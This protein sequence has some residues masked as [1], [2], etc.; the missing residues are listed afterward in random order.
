M[1]S[2]TINFSCIGG[3]HHFLHLA[4]VMA[5][6]AT[7]RQCRI[8]VFVVS[9]GDQ[10]AL[11][12]ILARLGHDAGNS[13]LKII[14]MKHPRWFIWLTRLYPKLRKSKLLRMLLWRRAF[15]G[16]D[17]I[18]AAER[19]S[20][21]LQRIPGKRPIMIHIP[22]GAGDRKRGFEPRIRL[23]DHVIA[24]GQ[25][26]RRRMISMGLVKPETCFVSGY[27]KLSGVLKMR[28][29][30][31]EKHIPAFSGN[32]PVVLY[33][34][35]FNAKLSS[36]HAYGYQIID[37]IL[38]DGR[39]DLIVAPHVRLMAGQSLAERERFHALTNNS[40]VLFDAGSE[41]SMDM[42]YTQAADIYLGD[43]S[44]Q[45]Y[46]FMFCPRPC[47][48]F[49]AHGAEWLGNPDYL[50]WTAGAVVSL[51]PALM[52]ALAAA[53]SRHCEFAAVQKALVSNAFGDI[54]GN[55]GQDAAAIILRLCRTNAMPG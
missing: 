25:K 6:L 24:G 41:K 47:V 37:A 52:A 30:R 48:F 10:A 38:A 14:I 27:V 15:R 39:Y 16:G 20:T 40:H 55:A 33:N 8:N 13:S 2:L 29:N 19:T 26:D 11:E 36:W 23:F 44:S 51:V 43:V 34:P 53:K 1:D 7:D 35:H 45:V 3:A 31:A 49:N 4:P 50:M 12:L 28:E 54:S 42:T 22:H 32:R 21:I 9:R 17:A 18:I 5:E 46:E